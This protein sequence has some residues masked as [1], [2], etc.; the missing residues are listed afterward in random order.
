M[1]VPIPSPVCTLGG[2]PQP[3]LLHQGWRVSRIRGF[4][5]GFGET[6]HPCV[7]SGNCT[8]SLT[9]SPAL[10]QKVTVVWFLKEGSGQGQSPLF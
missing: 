7:V 2:P 10:L 5:W 1:V 4:G 6:V 8:P 9:S 3:G